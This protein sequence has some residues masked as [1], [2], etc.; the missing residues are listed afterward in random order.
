M[1]RAK[2]QRV[3]KERAPRPERTKV[4]VGFTDM[5]FALVVLLLL[6]M[7]IVMMFSASYAI[8]IN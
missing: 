6:A 4:R 2:K 7:G 1:G 3:R 5:T 8:A